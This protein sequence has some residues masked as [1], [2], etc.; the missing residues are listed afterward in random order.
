MEVICIETAAFEELVNQVYQRLKEKDAQHHDKWI[1]PDE[2]M[3][4]LNCK[5]TKLQQLR[6]DGLL[7]YSQPD[8]KIILYDRDSISD[9]LE[10]NAKDTF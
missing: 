2:A 4:L 5:K 1:A 3:R 8:R 7:R 10:K 6:T 9:Y